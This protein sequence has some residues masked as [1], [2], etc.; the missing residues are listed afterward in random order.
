MAAKAH[1]MLQGQVYVGCQNV[2]A[3]ASAVMRHRIGLN[4]AAQSEGIT[5]DAVVAKIL[6]AIPQ[7]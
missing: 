2:A 7:S 5:P 1:A 3:I 4:F 6:E